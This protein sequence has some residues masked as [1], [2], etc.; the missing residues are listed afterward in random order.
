MTRSIV[1]CSS[2]TCFCVSVAAGHLAQ[3][4]A[5]RL[6]AGHRAVEP[7]D[8]L[9]EPLQR[10]VERLHG[11]RELGDEPGVLFEHLLH[12]AGLLVGR[13]HEIADDRDR[14]DAGR[15]AGAFGLLGHA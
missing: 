8:R 11:R 5:G 1:D 15:D 4:L 6:D 9:V 2:A 13:S 14:T 3:R 7:A 12:P 10:V